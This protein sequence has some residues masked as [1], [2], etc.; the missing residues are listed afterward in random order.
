MAEKVTTMVVKVDLQCPCCYREVKKLLCKF[1]Q[2]RNQIFDEKQN[3]VTITVV[4]CSPEKIRD[5]LCCKGGKTIKCIQIVEPKPPKKP[6]DSPP[7]PPPKEDSP[8]PPPPKEDCP[9]PPPPPKEDSPPPPPPGVP[10]AVCCGPC[11]EGRAGGPCYHGYGRRPVPV[12][13]STPNPPVPECP[14][15]HQMEAPTGL[16][17]ESCYE[18]RAGGP[19]Y[20]GYGRRPVP[21]PISTPPNPSMPVCP[22]V[23][24]RGGPPRV[25][26]GPCSEGRAGGPCYHGYG[27]LVPVPVPTPKPSPPKAPK[28]PPSPPQPVPVCP[29]IHQMGA[30]AGICCGSCYEGRAGGPC[31][32]GYGRSVSWYDGYY[33]YGGGR[34]CHVSRCDDYFSDENATGCTIM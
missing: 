9:P 1:P 12:L 23:H 13:I 4:C 5:K 14:P 29:P 16:C 10:V 3:T 24:Q 26:C 11:Y 20:H 7:P 27:R 19:C 31:Y 17:C 33:G 22:P 18:G 8:P 34:V 15:A 6:K 32:H 28:T 2:I 25:C 30:P 21:V